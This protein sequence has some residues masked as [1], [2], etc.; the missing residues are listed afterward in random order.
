MRKREGNMPAVTT[1]SLCVLALLS[2]IR[3]LLT[4]WPH[5]LCMGNSHIDCAEFA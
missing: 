5:F 4:L 2:P 1:S 3:G